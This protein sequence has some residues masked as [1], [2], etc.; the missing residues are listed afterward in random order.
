[1]TDILAE[2]EKPGREPRPAFSTATVAAGVEKVADLKAGMVGQG[3]VTTSR[4]LASSSTWVCISMALSAFQRWSIAL[5]QTRTRWCGPG[6]WCGSR[7]SM[8][9]WNASESG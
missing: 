3:V 2:L 6:T 1:V 9:T 5:F 4:P 7:S 8:S